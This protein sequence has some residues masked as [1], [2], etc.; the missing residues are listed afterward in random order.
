MGGGRVDL[1]VIYRTT[2]IHP[3]ARTVP[4]LGEEGSEGLMELP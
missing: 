4:R 2:L 1:Q 3:P